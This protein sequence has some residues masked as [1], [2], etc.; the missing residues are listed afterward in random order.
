VKTLL[1]LTKGEKIMLQKFITTSLMALV[2]SVGIP[3][4]A[5]NG[6]SVASA[7]VRTHTKYYRDSR[8]RLVAVRKP[9]FY[10][11]H[12]KFVNIAGGSAAGALVGGLIGGRKGVVI[13]GLAGAGGGALVTHKQKS[14]HY[15][16][17]Y[18]VRRRNY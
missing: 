16:W 8:G 3:F 5:E 12:R 13:G 6:A 17:R 15:T 11:R 2:L 7:Q 14:K 4:L 9:G 1:K 18:Y 10:R